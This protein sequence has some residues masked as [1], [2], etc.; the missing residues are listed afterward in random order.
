MRVKK[1][2]KSEQL[3][4]DYLDLMAQTISSIDALIYEIDENALQNQTLRKVSLEMAIDCVPLLR[5]L[6][7]AKAQAEISIDTFSKPTPE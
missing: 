5:C 3:R 2:S 4:H 7:E 1:Q 6:R